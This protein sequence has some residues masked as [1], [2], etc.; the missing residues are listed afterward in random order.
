[1]AH[2]KSP[3]P[4]KPVL[5]P[6][7][8]VTFGDLISL[9][10]TFFVLIYTFSA[11]DQDRFRR[12]TG[13]LTGGLGVMTPQHMKSKEAFVPPRVPPDVKT[14]LKGAAN[15]PK[16]RELEERMSELMQ[17]PSVF[18]R[19]VDFTELPDGYRIRL[20]GQNMFLPGDVRLKPVGR[21]V[22]IEIA[23]FFRQEPVRL[24]VEAHT[25]PVT[26][27]V[28]PGQD[29]HSLTR[30]IAFE[31]AKLLSVETEWKAWRI[32]A[33]G[34]GAGHPIADN[35]TEIGRRRNR[36]IEIQV[37]WDPEGRGRT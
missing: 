17:D 18:N 24:V 5:A 21:D 16:R 22:L 3:E 26:S 23:R 4:D 28:V 29:P 9:L 35:T 7:W 14:D 1:V 27:S 19:K 20:D 25:D 37:I 8:I 34:M 6:M 15:H 31:T 12:V 2:R 11:L 36:R 32:G 13:K 33:A 30:Q 10:V